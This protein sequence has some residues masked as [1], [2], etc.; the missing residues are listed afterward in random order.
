MLNSIKR[1]FGKKFNAAD[2][3]KVG[4]YNIFKDTV[5]PCDAYNPTG[6]PGDGILSSSKLIENLEHVSA[7]LLGK[8]KLITVGYLLDI[9]HS[10]PAMFGKTIKYETKVTEVKGNKVTFMTSATDDHDGTQYGYG[11]H[12]RAIIGTE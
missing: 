1:S 6:K 10:K 12:I 4:E 3:V 5:Y 7:Q 2:Y 8:K 9:N 11:T